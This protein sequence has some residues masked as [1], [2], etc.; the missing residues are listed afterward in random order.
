MDS[1]LSISSTVE[2]LPN[3]PLSAPLID[4]FVD[5]DGFFFSHRL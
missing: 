4:M 2:M 3:K 1:D 5:I